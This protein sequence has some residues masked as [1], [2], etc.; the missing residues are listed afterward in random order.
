MILQWNIS[1]NQKTVVC[2]SVLESLLFEYLFKVQSGIL[3]SEN[4]IY[5]IFFFFYDPS[6]QIVITIQYYVFY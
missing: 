6:I 2:E 5:G 1:Y 4:S 3:M